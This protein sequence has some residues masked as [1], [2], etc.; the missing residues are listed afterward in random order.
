[1]QKYEFSAYFPNDSQFPYKEFSPFVYFW[2]QLSI[3]IYTNYEIH[4]HILCVFALQ[5]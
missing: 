5:A 3:K 1:M 4:R 2:H